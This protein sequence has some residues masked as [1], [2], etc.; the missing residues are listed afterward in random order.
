MQKQLDT[1]R[2]AEQ[3]SDSYLI[4]TLGALPP[5]LT[6]PSSADDGVWICCCAHENSLT[7]FRGAFPFKHLRC[8]K[9]KHVM[10][11]DCWTSEILTPI[12]TVALGRSA[13]LFNKT[14][15]TTIRF[16]RVCPICGLSHRAHGHGGYVTF[17]A[18][19][20]PCGHVPTRDDL[21]FAIGSVDEF[22]QDPVGTAT[23]LRV[24]RTLAASE[25]WAVENDVRSTKR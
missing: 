18:T 21:Q 10:C 15:D 12:P 11:T 6:N 2:P 8:S 17:P 25:R 9:C 19:I 22:R 1:A 23:M 7:H 3:V 24:E 16:C 20:C 14:I 4:R 13:G 5:G